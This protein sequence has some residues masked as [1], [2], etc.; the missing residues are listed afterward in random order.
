ME[1]FNVTL[2]LYK[3]YLVCVLLSTDVQEQGKQW[4]TAQY[5]SGCL[6]TSY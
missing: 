5:G 4:I 1:L 6:C 3:G 2:V